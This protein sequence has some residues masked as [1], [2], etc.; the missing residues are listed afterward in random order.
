M[1]DKFTA[2]WV[3]HSSI[4]DFLKCPRLYY[5]RNVYKNPMTGRK[6]TLIT[7]PL[8]LG[9]TVHDV[10]ESL[11][12]MPVEERL[13]KPLAKKLEKAWEEITG[14][15]GGFKSLAE[16]EEYKE[17]ARAMLTRVEAN[18]GPILN[19]AVKIKSEDHLPPRYFLSEED[20]IILNGKIDWLEHLPETDSLHI[21]DFKTGRREE[22]E[23][24]LQLPIYHLIAANTQARP[25]EKASFW[26]LELD[27]AP[28]EFVLPQA[29]ETAEKVLAIAKRI[30][31]ARQIEHFKCPRGGCPY[32]LPYEAIAKGQ[33]EQVGTS[34]YQDIFV[35]N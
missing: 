34:S 2:T 17:R 24:S 35:L 18:P 5:L 23:D 25:I 26:Y 6:I 9:Q 27:N 3:S 8:A 29:S 33:G 7:P 15:K 20:N 10:I 30:K 32:C 19:K 21:I 11:S 16:E 12:I 13:S 1:P 4:N 28:K 22:E 14:K 31:L